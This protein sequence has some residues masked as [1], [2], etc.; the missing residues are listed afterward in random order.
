LNPS[1]P[2]YQ[3]RILEEKLRHL[4]YFC[5]LPIDSFMN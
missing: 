2:N 3:K 1:P 4:N 5:Q